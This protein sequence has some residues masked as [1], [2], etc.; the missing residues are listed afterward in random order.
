LGEKSKTLM[1]FRRMLSV[2]K[3]MTDNPEEH[4]ELNL[5]QIGQEYIRAA[6]EAARL[7]HERNSLEDAGKVIQ[8]AI[9]L[10]PSS[11]ESGDINLL[12]DILISQQLYEE[13]MEVICEHCDAKFEAT[14]N[15]AELS[16]LE[17]DQQLQAFSAVNLP[18]S[19]PQEIYSKLVIIL[20]QLNAKHLVSNVASIILDEDPEEFGDLM[21]DI[22][23]AYMNKEMY[24][25]S[26]PFLEKLINSVNYGQAAVWLRYGESLYGLGKLDESEMA[27]KKVISLAPQH[28]DARRSLSA[29]L[30]ELGRPDEALLTLDQDDE[31]ELLNPSLLYEKC[32]LLFSE[33]RMEEFSVKAELLL[34]RNFTQIRNKEEMYAIAAQKRL[35]KKTKAIADVRTYRQEPL[36]DQKEADFEVDTIITP[37]KEY[38][39]FHKLCEFYFLNKRYPEF[40]RLTFSALGSPLF[41][42]SEDTMKECEFL[43]LVASFSNGDSYHAYNF[44]R[45]MVVKDATNNRLWNLFNLVISRAEDL[46]HNRFLMR[47]MSRRPDNLAL[48]ILNGHNCLVAGTYKYSLGEYMSAF[49][50]DRGKN[51]LVA[52]M[53]G[54]TFIH[55]ACQKFSARKHSLVV[56]ACAFL[57]TYVKL[58]GKC[59][60]TFYNLGRAMHQ[61]GILPAALHYYKKALEIGPIIQPDTVDKDSSVNDSEPTH[62]IYDLSRE[63]AHNIAL[64]YQSSG[65]KELARMYLH[66]YIVV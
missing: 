30:T 58:R 10:H 42:K 46:R 32:N 26:L 34:S 18:D 11:A 13:A 63:T 60:E 14:T 31:A 21:L 61:L 5:Q 43:C 1:A 9:T 41:N 17:S 59:Q 65:N 27:Y 3:G 66:K 50:Q 55:M 49:K 33:G 8:E 64:I 20:L 39:L 35:N 47:F 29:I 12:L 51:P 48:G 57:N 44:V 53:L 38:E 37:Q 36:M 23:E 7:Y 56:Q 54:L 15:P 40:Q 52:L 24:E 16:Q 62:N 19:T 6:R 2:L 45:D 4:G 28:H 25:E 22:G